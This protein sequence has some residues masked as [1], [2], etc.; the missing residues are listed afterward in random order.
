MRIS[1]PKNVDRSVRICLQK[2]A[3]ALDESASPVFAGLNLTSF[4]L[5]NTIT[6]ISTDGTLAGNSDSVVPTEKAVKTY[7]DS[8]VAASHAF[9]TITGITNDVVA[10]AANDTLTLASANAALTIVGTTATDTI[11]FTVDETNIDHDQLTNFVSGEHFLQTAITNVSTALSTGLLKVTTETGALSVVTD[12]SANWNSAFTHVS[13]DGTD[14]IYINQDLRTTAIPTFG[15]TE[16]T[17]VIIGTSAFVNDEGRTNVGLGYYA[18]ANNDT[19]GAGAEGE[20][21]VYIGYRAGYGATAGPTVNTGYGNIGIGYNV[22]FLNTSGYANVALG[23]SAL[24]SNTTGSL[25][26]AFGF[27]ALNLN[28]GGIGNSAIGGYSLQNNAGG[29]YNMAIGFGALR[30]NTSG[31]DNIG[32]GMYASR[33]N[34]TGSCN[35]SIGKHTDGYGAGGVNS[36]SNNTIIGSFAGYNVTTGGSNV[37]IGYQAGYRQT[38]LGDRLIIDNVDR[39][40][41]A[42][43]I[44]NSLIYGVFNAASA[45]QSL[46]INGY[47][48]IKEALKLLERSSDPLEPAEGEC[49]IWLSDGTGKG[50]DGDVIIASQ[51]GGTTNYGTLFNHSDGAAW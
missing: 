18:G 11:T 35:T 24:Y 51:A 21:N 36:H 49:V 2:L 6:E 34:Q 32:I 38:T 33:Y 27:N 45:S 39:T 13:S 1:V 14:H 7:A 17:N 31:G 25:N 26:I 29:N 40:S 20:K 42:N 44:I 47:G 22:M 43:E 23:E 5:V 28:I 19:T 12:N 15:S 10:D 48:I 50:D 16:P 41:A 8:V 9:K 4:T 3:A 46:R 30:A 37:F